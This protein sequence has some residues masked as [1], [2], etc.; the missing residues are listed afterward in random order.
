MS[1]DGTEPCRGSEV[2]MFR[3]CA[4]LSCALTPPQARV[5][6]EG[7]CILDTPHPRARGVTHYRQNTSATPVRHALVLSDSVFSTATNHESTEPLS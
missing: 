4:A 6:R 1:G 5:G 2:L 3:R 7:T